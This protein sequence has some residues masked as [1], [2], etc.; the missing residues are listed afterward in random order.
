MSFDFLFKFYEIV[1][2]KGFIIY[3]GNVL[4]DDVFYKDSLDDVF[5]LGW[6][7][8]LVIEMEVVMLYYLVVKFDVE[9]L[10]IMMVSD[11]L[12]IGEEIM[13]EEC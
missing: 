7:G 10:V 2:V 11:S 13:V 6:Y 3:V 1:K 9:V 5:C 8:V 12:V 4:L